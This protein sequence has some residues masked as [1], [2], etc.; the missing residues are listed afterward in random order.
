MNRSGYI[1]DL[2]SDDVLAFG[3]WRAQVK[4]AIRGK[5]GQAFLR[6]LAQIMDATPPEQRRL[7]ANELINERGECCTIG[8]VCRSRGVDVS[9]VDIEDTRA[10][11]EAV[12]IAFQLVAEIEFENDEGALFPRNETSEDR[13]VRMR[14]WV[15]RRIA[16]GE[17]EGSAS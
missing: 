4:N 7:I 9:R 16:K 13:W 3:R 6:E 2:A 12:G 8:L 1:E 14:A 15:E 10:V 5:R 11:G 17:S